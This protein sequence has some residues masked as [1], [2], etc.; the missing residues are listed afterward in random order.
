M[1]ELPVPYT[2]TSLVSGE[3]DTMLELFFK[4]ED[5]VI[6]FCDCLFRDYKQIDL[7][8]EADSAWG[9]RIQFHWAEAEELA[10]PGEM[11]AKAM[12]SVFARHRLS[13]IV[14]DIIKHKYYYSDPDEVERIH[15]LAHWLFQGSSHDGMLADDVPPA[16]AIEAIFKESITGKTQ[17][18]FDSIVKFRQPAIRQLL[19]THVGLAIDEFKRE[20]DHQAFIHVLREYVSKKR[21]KAGTVYVLQG[22]DFSFYKESG[23]PFSKAELYRLM[24]QEPLYLVGLHENEWNLSPLIALAPEKLRIYGDDPQEP[25]TLTVVNIFEEKAELLPLAAFPFRQGEKLKERLD[26]KRGT[27]L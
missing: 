17:I 10:L 4:E 13:A 23:E 26:L 25:K 5:E 24:H 27:C 21:T 11:I 20:E 7:K 8:W 22:E 16:E 18:H 9:N 12:S 1:F 6:W 14:T 19:I 2:C 3:G 15:E